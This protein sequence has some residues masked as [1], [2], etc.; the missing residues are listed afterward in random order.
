[1]RKT[2]E[3][4]LA[5]GVVFLAV[6]EAIPGCVSTA[7]HHIAAAQVV[8]Q[9]I[10]DGRRAVS[11]SGSPTRTRA[12]RLWLSITCRVLFCSVARRG[13]VDVVLEQ[14]VDVDRD[15]GL[16]LLVDAPAS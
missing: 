9:V 5:V 6:D 10:L 12:T 2:A 15:F 4:G 1:M 3:A 8:A 13:R 16:L 14:A 7:N 11:R